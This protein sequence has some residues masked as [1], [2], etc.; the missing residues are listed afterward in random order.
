MQYVLAVCSLRGCLA[1]IG[2][3][4]SDFGICFTVQ[5]TAMIHSYR[6]YG[7]RKWMN[8]C[9]H[10]GATRSDTAQSTAVW[11]SHQA[12]RLELRESN[13]QYNQTSSYVCF[14]K[15]TEWWK[16]AVHE[17][18]NT[19]SNLKCNEDAELNEKK[20]DWK[21]TECMDATLFIN[22]NNK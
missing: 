15:P 13:H 18:E 22:N 7:N 8:S 2:I 1:S 12:F 11:T 9:P 14:R 17:I 5:C 10:M 20:M 3:R 6:S 16:T 21:I 19:E 4:M